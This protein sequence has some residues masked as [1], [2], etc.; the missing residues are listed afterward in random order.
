M[1]RAATL[2]TARRWPGRCKQA[3]WAAALDVTEIEP[4]GPASPLWDLPNII[5]SPH[6]AGG[7]STGYPQQKALFGK[8]LARL[9]AGE[10]LLNVCRVGTAI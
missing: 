9:A 1:W 6:V 3:G 4:L 2:W 5:I 7:G 8:N 10:P